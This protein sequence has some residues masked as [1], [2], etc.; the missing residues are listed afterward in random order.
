M[1]TTS[2]KVIELPNIIKK[3]D[4]PALATKVQQNF[5]ELQYAVATVQNYLNNT[6]FA[7]MDGNSEFEA[8]AITYGLDANKPTD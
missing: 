2:V 6:G 5:E 3:N 4:D 1:A 8:K 7:A